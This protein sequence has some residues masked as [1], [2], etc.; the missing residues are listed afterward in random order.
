VDVPTEH[1][2]QDEA[3]VAKW[4]ETANEAEHRTAIFD[5]F[6]AE[7]SALAPAGDLRV[8][9]LGSGPG[10]LAEQICARVDVARYTAADISP[11]MHAIARTRLAPW[12]PVVELV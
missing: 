3:Y 5:A 8:L 2:W 10:Y 9:E 1:R 4:A 12:E 7:L 11:Y 6:V